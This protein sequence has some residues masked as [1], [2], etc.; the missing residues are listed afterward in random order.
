MCFNL[1]TILATV[2]GISSVTANRQG[3]VSRAKYINMTN[4]STIANTYYLLASGAGI[5]HSIYVSSATGAPIENALV[6]IQKPVGN[7]YITLSHQYTDTTGLSLNYLDSSTNYRFAVTKSGYG[8]ETFN[9]IPNPVSPIIYVRL[10]PT[11]G[12]GADYV[13]ISTIFSN[14]SYSFL[15]TLLYQNVTFN[16][17]FSVTDPDSK[18]TY[19]KINA[20]YPNGS[21]MCSTAST[22]PGG[23]TVLCPIPAAFGIYCVR[24]MI[25]RTGF[26]NFTFDPI[27]Y[28]FY[29]STA[30]LGG[31][32]SIIK[33]SLSDMGYFVVAIVVTLCVC[34]FLATFGGGVVVAFAAVGMFAFLAALNPTAVI[35]MGG[36]M[37]PFWSIAA[38]MAMFAVVIMVLR[39][40]I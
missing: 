9:S 27:C 12:S 17:S 1:N 30:G 2:T 34:A 36:I 6:T 8:S 15:P 39:S 26:D 29:N 14:I 18:I 21:L 5:Y 23:T 28:Q 25:A 20:T 24:G 32:H 7:I 16:V 4:G 11:S 31:I 22:I 3:Y 37:I 13:N 33:S 40:Y 19:Q 10:T 38:L 35:P